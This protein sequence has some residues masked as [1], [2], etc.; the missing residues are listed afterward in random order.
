M[1]M[2][3]AAIAVLVAGVLTLIIAKYGLRMQTWVEH[4]KVSPTK[5]YVA[6]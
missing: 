4:G 5:T 6:C 3:T 1:L 2:C